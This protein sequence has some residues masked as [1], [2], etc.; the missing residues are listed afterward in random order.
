MIGLVIN[1]PEE[2]PAD[3]I[4]NKQ[5][6]GLLISDSQGNRNNVIVST[7][8][9]LLNVKCFNIPFSIPKCQSITYSAR[10]NTWTQHRCLDHILIAI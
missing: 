6:T 9:C 3:L 2:D 7:V 8:F 1:K 10:I 4:H 5:V